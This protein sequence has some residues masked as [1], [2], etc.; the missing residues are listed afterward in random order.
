VAIRGK[1]LVWI[2][3]ALSVVLFVGCV[4]YVA[5]SLFQ[6]QQNL[7][8]SYARLDQ[9]KLVCIAIRDH[10]ESASAWPKIWA[11]I[12]PHLKM[13][14]AEAAEAEEEIGIDYSVTLEQVV[15]DTTE[16]PAW[17]RVGSLPVPPL[18]VEWVRE[19]AKSALSRS[20]Q[21]KPNP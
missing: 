8:Q 13:T 21:T 9:A 11:D 4:A 19:S 7:R 3:I 10:I 2:G 12:R 15:A 14:D 16:L 17:L 20:P 5:R 18:E 6:F 1:Y